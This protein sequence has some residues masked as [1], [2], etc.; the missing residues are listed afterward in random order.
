V[1]EMDAD[2]TA[3][4]GE[5]VM[6]GNFKVTAI[7]GECA[8]LWS[9]WAQVTACPIP[10]DLELGHPVSMSAVYR[11]E[12][13]VEATTW[14]I[15]RQLW[16]KKVVGLSALMLTVGLVGWDLRRRGRA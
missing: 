9:P 10:A 4:L 14:R 13:R 11:G 8:D 16:I 3:H 7:E 6:L 1:S 2:P 12:G 5:R 15:H